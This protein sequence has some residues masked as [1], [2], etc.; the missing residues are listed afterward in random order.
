MEQRLKQRLIGAVVL[1]ALAVIFVPMLLQGPV[2][3]HP[4]DIPIEIPPKPVVNAT[5][6]T[7]AAE[8]PV[9]PVASAPFTP[10]QPAD[11]AASSA[12]ALQPEQ[13]EPAVA[14]VPA[15]TAPVSA[16][17][18]LS[19]TSRTPSDLAAWAVQVGS[20]GTES[21][22]RG[23]RDSLRKKGYAAFV[24]SIKT[25]GNT[26]YRVRVGPTAQREEA[27]RLQAA[28]AKKESMKGL[29]VPHP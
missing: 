6:P 29:V 26:F 14:D 19:T 4:T 7:P 9:A 1:V 23:L 27:E 8:R 3:R 5:P 17:E 20:F 12:P 2:E 11:T 28:L 18:P 21:N 10:S 24:E 15:P 22:A 13:A 25:D 16:Q